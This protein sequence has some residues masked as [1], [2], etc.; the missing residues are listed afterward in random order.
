MRIISCRY[1]SPVG[2]LLLASFQERLCMC[3]WI[4][5]LHHSANIERV[6]KGLLADMQNGFSSTIDKAILQLDEYFE[7]R[8]E[9]FDVPLLLV[10]TPFQRQVWNTLLSIPYG[11]TV[12]YAEQAQ[13]MGR[14]QSV[15]AV[16]NAN[17]RNAISIIVPCHRVIGR[18]HMLVGYA[19]GLE[20]KRRLLQIEGSLNGP[21]FSRF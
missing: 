8:R 5:S 2:V 12:S 4:S 9:M 17:G 15:R 13:R 7:G 11:K 21:S 16:A 18:D 1:E 3:D 14:P 10:G 20:T 19:G 6:C